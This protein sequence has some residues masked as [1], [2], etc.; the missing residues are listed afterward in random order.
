[1]FHKLQQDSSIFLIHLSCHTKTTCWND[2]R[3][4]S[5]VA[6]EGVALLST[7]TM[8]NSVSLFGITEMSKIK[9]HPLFFL[10]F[11]L[12][13]FL[14]QLTCHNKTNESLINF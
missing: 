8:Q 2:G 6:K 11:C 9:I 14:A 4:F 7:A 10:F 13:A 12:F 1:M 3:C 5:H